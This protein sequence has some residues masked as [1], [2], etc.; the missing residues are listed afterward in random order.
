MINVCV[1]KDKVVDLCR[2]EAEFSVHGIG[3]KTFTLEHTTIEEYVLAKICSYKMLA[4]C[5]F[6]GRPKKSDLHG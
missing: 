6:A 2:I 5:H 4:A 3:F 1:G